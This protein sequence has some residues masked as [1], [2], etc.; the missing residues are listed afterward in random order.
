LREAFEKQRTRQPLVPLRVAR[1]QGLELEWRAED[2]SRPSQ[3]GV[4][5][6]PVSLEQLVPYIDW[7]PF[8]HTWE[9]KGAWPS[10][11]EHKETGPRARE[12]KRD[13]DAM[14]E[15][16]VAE[17]WLVARAVRGLWRAHA[18]GDDVVLLAED[19]KTELRRLPMLR[20]QQQKDTR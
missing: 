1:E 2:L 20:Q 11:L 5:E 10:I 15:R 17:R 9:L 12:L 13:A 8:F 3:L 18:D 14:L 19:G 7:S 6:E 16:I 4:H